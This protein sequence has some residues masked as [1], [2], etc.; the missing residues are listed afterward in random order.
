LKGSPDILPAVTDVL[1]NIQ[2]KDVDTFLMEIFPKASGKAQREIISLFSN[3]GVT[4]AAPLL[5]E[6]ISPRK[7]WEPEPNH[8]LQEHV[9]RTLGELRSQEAEGALIDAAR[10][11]K[12]TTMLKPKPSFVRAAAT[13]ALTRMPRNHRVNNALIQLKRDSSPLVRKA[14]ELSEIIRE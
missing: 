6:F 9:C 8:S 11:P 1:K 3:R 7:F 12:L 10:K 14:A 4:E 13:W 5:L 2:D